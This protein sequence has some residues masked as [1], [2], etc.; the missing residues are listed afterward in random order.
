M[1]DNV[2]ST[3]RNKMSEIR[4]V[5]EEKTAA[6]ALAFILFSRKLQRESGLPGIINGHVA[7]PPVLAIS[8]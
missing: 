3:D 1:C 6:T 8:L 4:T 7:K 5:A 2:M